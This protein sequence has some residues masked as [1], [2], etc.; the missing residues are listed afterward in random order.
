MRDVIKVMVLTTAIIMI[1]F[2]PTFFEPTSNASDIGGP[3][4]IATDESQALPIVPS[5]ATESNSDFFIHIGD[6]GN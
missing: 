2:S 1:I 3:V 6:G 4:A 5:S